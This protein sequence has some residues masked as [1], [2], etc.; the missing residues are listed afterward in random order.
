MYLS[1]FLNIIYK[2]DVYMRLNVLNYDKFGNK[3]NPKDVVLN[4]PLI[5]TLLKK[6]LKEF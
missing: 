3:L 2:G 4:C 6:Y 1:A 5:Y